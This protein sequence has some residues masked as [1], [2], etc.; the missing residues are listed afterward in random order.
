MPKYDDA[1][2]KCREDAAGGR[3]S[4]LT[5][6]ESDCGAGMRRANA[7]V[8]TILLGG[9]ILSAGCSRSSQLATQT[10]A[11]AAMKAPSAPQPPAPPPLAAGYP[12]PA[13]D[14]SRYDPEKEAEKIG[15]KL[16]P[17]AR[18][19]SM[20]Y[21]IRM[22]N[23]YQQR[24]FFT[25]TDGRGDV[26][27]FYDQ[28]YGVGS[29]QENEAG[30]AAASIVQV[31]VRDSYLFKVHTVPDGETHIEVTAIRTCEMVP[32]PCGENEHPKPVED[33]SGYDPETEAEKVGIKLYPGARILST[34]Y[35]VQRGNYYQQ[36]AFFTTT[37][38]HDDVVKFYD[39]IYGVGTF[40]QNSIG[41]A[42]ASIVQAASHEAHLFKTYPAPEGGTNI[43]VTALRP[44]EMPPAP[45]GG[46]QK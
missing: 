27:K 24:A 22:G 34:P 38:G 20:P 3:G 17:G 28:I 30:V 44:C 26:V 11:P 13:E 16:Y 15:I 40:R 29:F 12:R 10:T 2:G 45:C 35:A 39:Q 6:I 1:A 18:I 8:V 37:D 42:A 32:A 21:Q 7:A 46:S 14:T 36:R 33:T 5:W 25:T 41:V 9:L 4:I 43:E 19:L 31:G 23:Y